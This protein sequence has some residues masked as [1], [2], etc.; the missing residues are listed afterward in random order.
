MQPTLSSMFAPDGAQSAPAKNKLSYKPSVKAAAR[1]VLPHFSQ[2]ELTDRLR[3]EA[4]RIEADESTEPHLSWLVEGRLSIG[5]LPKDFTDSKQ[6]IKEHNLRYV[7]CVSEKREDDFFQWA[8]DRGCLVLW[9]PLQGRTKTKKSEIAQLV[10]ICKRISTWLIKCSDTPPRV[11]PFSV[12]ICDSLG[13]LFSAVPAAAIMAALGNAT[14]EQ[15]CAVVTRAYVHRNRHRYVDTESSFSRPP[16]RL[17][18]NSPNLVEA[19]QDLTKQVTSRSISNF[20][21]GSIGAARDATAEQ[22]M[23]GYIADMLIL[24][25]GL[26]WTTP[27]AVPEGLS[28]AQVQ[29][30]MHKRKTKWSRQ[31][32]A[33]REGNKTGL[34]PELQFDADCG[35]GGGFMDDFAASEPIQEAPRYT[36]PSETEAVFSAPFVPLAP[37]PPR[38]RG[39]AI[40][41]EEQELLTQEEDLADYDSNDPFIRKQLARIRSQLKQ[42]RQADGM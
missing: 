10:D 37:P 22:R 9:F 33:E 14:W 36:A 5:D 40:S 30:W 13:G 16:P 34:E 31:R 24:T 19:V 28:P 35:G 2:I 6:F 29:E 20:V 4:A 1:Q 38:R 8:D 41:E 42:L 3:R 23:A 21:V 17:L 26:Q 15:G 12:H 11:Q 27:N 32:E 18:P 39:R 7:L 25:H